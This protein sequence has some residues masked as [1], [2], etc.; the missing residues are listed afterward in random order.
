MVNFG[1]QVVKVSRKIVDFGQEAVEVFN[2]YKRIGHFSLTVVLI[3]RNCVH[4]KT[5]TS[6]ERG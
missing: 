6:W 2:F 4:L 1:P 5:F 3:C